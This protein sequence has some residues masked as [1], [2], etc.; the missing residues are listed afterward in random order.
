MRTLLQDCLDKMLASHKQWLEDGSG[1]RLELINRRL[2]DLD[3]RGSDLT[4]A[5]FLNCR[6]SNVNMEKVTL[7]EANIDMCEFE[8]TKFNYCTA[9]KM[10][11]H[12]KLTYCEIEK[13]EF[14]DCNMDNCTFDNTKM[15]SRWENCC[16]DF[17]RLVSCVLDFSVF[18]G[19]F[20][21]KS[22]WKECNGKFFNINAS[23]RRSSSLESAVFEG[24]KFPH[25]KMAGI[26]LPVHIKECNFSHSDFSHSSGAPRIEKSRFCS[27]NFKGATLPYMKVSETDFSQA[28]FFEADLDQGHF[29]NC[30]FVMA[31]F[32]TKDGLVPLLTGIVYKGYFRALKTVFE[33]CRFELAKLKR[34]LLSEAQF[35]NCVMTGCSLSESI[36]GKTAFHD[37]QL[38]KSFWM[39]AYLGEGRLKNCDLSE[40]DFSAVHV[41]GAFLNDVKWDGANTDNTIF[42]FAAEYRN[43]VV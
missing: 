31:E 40:S 5:S 12:A 6:F 26:S 14:S 1:N 38:N 35:K 39:N 10:E 7:K 2:V 36:M 25:A 20:F 15:G 37:C 16:F 34:T 41:N 27:A 22:T 33:N 11:F 42:E 19:C 43:A 29:K 32:G 17:G 28:S 4:K 24:C 23:D 3:F 30:L 9:E 8:K 18:E 21:K 13:A